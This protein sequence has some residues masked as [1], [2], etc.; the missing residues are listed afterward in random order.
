VRF[1]NYVAYFTLPTLLPG[2][3]P[4][5]AD[6]LVDG[7][8]DYSNTLEQVVYQVPTGTVAYANPTPIY[9]L[10]LT[11]YA[12]VSPEGSEPGPPTGQVNFVVD[13]QTYPAT[14]DPSTDTAQVTLNS[15]LPVGQQSIVAEYVGDANFV[16]SVSSPLILEVGEAPTTIQVSASSPSTDFGQ[17]TTFQ[18]VVRS[19]S[20]ATPSGTVEFFADGQAIG[21]STVGAGGIATFSLDSLAPGTHAISA[22]YSSDPA[23]FASSYSSGQTVI[24]TPAPTTTVLSASAI[25][26]TFGSPVQLT[27][28]VVAFPDT[29]IPAG[30][31]TFYDG[32]TLL[33]TAPLD[34]VG[35]ATLI[36]PATALPGGQDSITATYA[37]TDGDDVG[38]SSPVGLVSIGGAGT[39]LSLSGAATAPVSNQAPGTQV[40]GQSYTFSAVVSPLDSSVGVPTG[41]VT[42]FDGTSPIGTV[43]LVDG[44]AAFSTSKLG[45]G[46]HTIFAQ[47]DPSP[48]F[49]APAMVGPGVVDVVAQAATTAVVSASV[50]STTVGQPVVFQATVRAVAPGIG[51]PIGMLQFL[52]DGTALGSPVPLVD[53]QAQ[54]STSQLSPGLHT[55]T[56]YF[57]GGANFTMSPPATGTISILSTYAGTGN[58]G[59][60]GDGGPAIQATFNQPSGVAVASKGDVFI[61]DT[62]NNRVRMIA[63]DGIITT[64]AG[65]GVAGDSGDGGPA[66][67]AEL[68]HPEAVAVDALGDLFIA[69][70]GNDAVREIT[71]SGMILTVLAG[72]QQPQGIAVDSKGL[73]LYVSDTG[74]DT[75]LEVTEVGTVVTPG[76]FAGAIPTKVVP[77]AGTGSPGAGLDGPADQSALDQ[78]SGLAVDSQGDLFIADTANNLVRMVTPSTGMIVTVAGQVGSTDNN[79]GGLATEAAL[80][81]PRDV[82]VDALGVIFIADTG[83]DKI[84]VVTPTRVGT[85]TTINSGGTADPYQGGTITSINSGNTPGTTFH[86]PTGVGCSPGA[87]TAYVGNTN[88]NNILSVADPLAGSDDQSGVA[89]L[90]GDA[91]SMLSSTNTAQLTSQL[92]PLNSS[93]LEL[94]ATLTVMAIEFNVD[95]SAESS[96]AAALPNQPPS[97][98][99]QAILTAQEEAA[100]ASQQAGKPGS[101]VEPFIQN[102]MGLDAPAVQEAPAAA[103]ATEA[104]PTPAEGPGQADFV[105]SPAPTEAVDEAIRSLALEGQGRLDL[106]SPEI[107]GPADIAAFANP[108]GLTGALALPIGLIAGVN[109]A[110]RRAVD[111]R[112]RAATRPV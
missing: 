56:A 1:S 40:F 94:L 65:T 41:G 16:S 49:A 31:V 34:A 20:Q 109:L 38:S 23:D 80:H 85:I 17:S 35:V 39:T 5:T 93:S 92:E 88:G 112:R 18:A 14:L 52:V 75:V 47:Y 36:T 83:D 90:V 44:M 70:T 30:T 67:M 61:A 100:L 96:S 25:A 21:T 73:H 28:A 86:Q 78:P 108:G 68:D 55:I 111:I 24:V 43:A 19:T 4:I 101:G 82:A 32:S 64:V 2:E 9:G 22:Y 106:P 51:L 71:A 46:T 11:L 12:T 105:P 98:A 59:F 48:D 50:S 99:S 10:P 58:A 81:Q 63:P 33:G 29:F 91:S 84:R 3:Y 6:Y 104:S 89:I 42:F 60:G 69:D 8:D 76:A 54:A 72:L 107:L 37:D 102:L 79:D 77:V 7:G 103:P 45:A 26:T 66:T 95:A 62:A 15:G 87:L 13:G 27:A 53:G 97:T 110:R 57:L 74:A